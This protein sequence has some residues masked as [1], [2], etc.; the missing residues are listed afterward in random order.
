MTTPVSPAPATDANHTQTTPTLDPTPA[1]TPPVIST[2]S[3]NPVPSATDGDE[4]L[5][6]GGKKALAAERARVKELN[7]RLKELEPLAKAH[8]DAQESAKSETT[9]LNEALTSERDARTKA[10]VALLRHTIAADKGVPSDLVKFLTGSS[11]EEIEQSAAELLDAVGNNK[12]AMPGRPVE[13]MVNGRPSTSSL[14]KDDP[15][16]LIRKGRGELP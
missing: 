9:K 13:R 16:T 5:G 15:V 7:D 11:K 3:T 1:G 14:D 4:V 6:E 8:A 12:P 10:E 2:N